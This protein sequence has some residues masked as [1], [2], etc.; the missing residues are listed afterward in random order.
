MQLYFKRLAM[1]QGTEEIYSIMF[2]S[3]KHPAR[4]KIL[5]ILAD[6]PLAFSEMLELLGISSSNLTYHLENLGEL[7]SKDEN[8]VYRLSTFG[9]ASVGTM[10]IVEEAPEVHPQ[11]RNGKTKKWKAVTAVLLISIIAI[12]S[13]YVIQINSMSQA[14]SER[15]ALQAK[16][17]QLLAWSTTTSSAIGFLQDVVQ[18]D[19]SKYQET[20]LSRTVENRA[21]LGG[22]VQEITR[23]SLTSS[24]SK[25]DVVF[26]FRNNKLCQYQLTVVEGAP[27]YSVAQSH[28][29]LDTA[30]YLLDRFKAYQ[31]GS[32]LQNMSKVLAMVTASPAIEIKEGNLKLNASFTS[33]NDAQINVLYTENNVDF[34]PKCVSLEFQGRTLTKLTDDWYL[35]TIGST[36]LTV[37]SE[38]AVELARNALNGYSDSAI[39]NFKVISD[40]AP[41]AIFHP[42]TKSDLALYPQWTVT[43]YLDKV[44]ANN[45]YMIAVMVWADTGEIAAI[46][47][48][49][50]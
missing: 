1:P 28:V 10:K 37:S 14:A 27:I 35:F 6:K 44:Y 15:D 12:A 9:Q 34:S 40:P 26:T 31:G 11:K 45:Y 49:N 39:S 30:N 32:Y 41:T 36:T 18:I 21:D 17:N 13:V 20:L 24:G 47:P 22:M 33:D 23:Y 46:K 5:R 8:G 7:V 50:I 16:Y 25:L 43:F 4:R 2:S 38:R 48:L 29:V 3:L 19:V 42:S